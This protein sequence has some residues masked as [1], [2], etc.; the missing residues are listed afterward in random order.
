MSIQWSSLRGQ[1]RSSESPS[2]PMLGMN[3]WPFHALAKVMPSLSTESLHQ[4]RAC[5]DGVASFQ[6]VRAFSEESQAALRRA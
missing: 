4:H 1:R 5:L 3:V 6:M 2:R